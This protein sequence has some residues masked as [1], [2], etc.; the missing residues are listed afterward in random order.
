MIRNLKVLGLALL[1][2]F[3]FAAVGASAASAQNG[4]VFSSEASEFTL[5]GVETGVG[6]N[7]LTAFGGRVECPGSTYTGHKY[8][9]TPH[10][11]I[12]TGASS[13]T[14]TPK[15]VNCVATAL[16]FPATVTMNGCDY[17][18]HLEGTKEGAAD[19]YGILATLVCPGIGPQVHIYKIGAEHTEAN[20][21]CT[22]TV[23]PNVAGYKG[24]HA[25]DT[26]NGHIDITGE[27]TGLK[28]TQ[29]EGP[30]KG[31]L[32]A[33]TTDENGKLDVDITVD[34]DNSLGTTIGVGIKHK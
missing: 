24:L 8:N 10:K 1:A 21:K 32:S 33:V 29:H 27:V 18:F 17:A 6:T 9:E 7:R 4:E 26:T 30:A 28:V 23:D 16:K 13:V 31:C 22:I 20:L 2:V 11:L 14:I 5:T 15:Y 25:T 12:P 3:A 19:T 34:A